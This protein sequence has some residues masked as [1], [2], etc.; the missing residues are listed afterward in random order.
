MWIN[1]RVKDLD[2]TLPSVRFYQA[3]TPDTR[4]Y[5]YILDVHLASNIQNEIRLTILTAVELSNGLT[6]GAVDLRKVLIDAGF[7]RA[8]HAS[9]ASVSRL[10]KRIRDLTPLLDSLS[11]S[12]ASLTIAGVNEELTE[13]P[14][15]PSVVAHDGVGPHL[16]WTPPTATFD[17]QV[18]ADILMALS[19]ELC[20]VGTS[21]FGR[22]GATDCDDLFYDST[23][24]GSKRFCTDP[25]C[26]S[27]THTA[28]HRARKKR[29]QQ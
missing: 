22:C 15:C 19:Q 28:G 4:D 6:G 18:M 7:P 10:E 12:D 11:G 2:R 1:V 5:W 13:L 8:E 20:D 14:I 21:R 16:H 27:R 29:T 24:N 3:L 26:A 17:D 23:R 9:L 25:K